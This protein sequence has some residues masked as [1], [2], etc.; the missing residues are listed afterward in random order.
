MQHGPHQDRA[1]ELNK[2]LKEWRVE[3]SLPLR[4]RE[5][6]WRRI[7]VSQEAHGTRN[8]FWLSL[9]LRWESFVRKPVGVA[10]CLTFFTAVG[11]GFGLWHTQTFTARTESA[12][13]HAYFQSVSPTTVSLEQ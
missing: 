10:A 11:I 3:A 5:G 13:Q 12:W 1:D 6:V 9:L 7:A 4:F 2:V 8:S